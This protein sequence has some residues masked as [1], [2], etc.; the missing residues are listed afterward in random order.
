MQGH[1]VRVVGGAVHAG[2]TVEVSHRW[3]RARA[4]RKVGVSANRRERRCA[5]RE[6]VVGNGLEVGCAVTASE[7]VVVSRARVEGTVR[8]CGR[9]AAKAAWDASVTLL[10]RRLLPV[11]GGH[12]IFEARRGLELPLADNSP[13]DEDS[14]YRACN[15]TEDRDG[16]LGH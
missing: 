14:S 12:A 2:A 8:G 11:D 13:A 9:S 10:H 16:R 4:A 15:D 5:C 3:L 1:A 6:V 7:A